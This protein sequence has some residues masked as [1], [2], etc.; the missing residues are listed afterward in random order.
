MQVGKG[1][2]LLS[3]SDLT[4][5][6]AALRRRGLGARSTARHLSAVRGLYRFLL[7]SGGIRRD[8]T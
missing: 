3:P 2:V 6:L 7:G 1:T 8:P 4:G 5:Y